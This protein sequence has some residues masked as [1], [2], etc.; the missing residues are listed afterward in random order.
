MKESYYQRDYS[1]YRW[2]TGS[3]LITCLKG[4]TI[5]ALLSYFFY[6]SFWAL[7]PLALI[8][9][10]YFVREKDRR[11]RQAKE[12]LLMQF[13]EC[14]CSVQASMKAGY[15]VEN[16]FV[17]SRKDMAMLY[18]ENSSIYQ[19]LERIRRGLVLNISLEEQLVDFAKR[20][21]LEEIM[22]FADIFEVA[23]RSG[24]DMMQMMD[25]SAS[26]IDRK[27]EVRQEIL[28][29]LHGKMLEQTVMKA[30]PF[31][32]LS[33]ISFTYPGYFDVLYHNLWGVGIMTA[34]LCL[35]LGAYMLNDKIL[36]RIREELL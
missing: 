7:F 33:Y 35:Y 21:G 34:C 17:E 9:R 14:I 30:M 24:G 5:V 15:A 13:K 25:A 18:G 16:S 19:E 2:S 36:N 8:G 31:A 11:I 12:E 20:S 3:F 26:L 32:I 10:L 22:Q 27:M 28:T 23:K 29:I 4:T 1:K 6:R